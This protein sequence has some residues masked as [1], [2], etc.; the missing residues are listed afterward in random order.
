MALTLLDARVRRSLRDGVIDEGELSDGD[1][2]GGVTCETVGYIEVRLA[3]GRLYGLQCR[4]L[5]LRELV[6]QW[7]H[8]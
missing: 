3:V 7:H 4:S 2:L 1:S 6:R 5:H 8:R